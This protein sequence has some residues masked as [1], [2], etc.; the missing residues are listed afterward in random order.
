[1]R[2]ATY[3]FFG[4]AMT[5]PVL[6]LG[7][8][9]ASQ[10]PQ[11]PAKS[12][13][14]EEVVVTARLRTEKLK[15]V[16]VA[17]TALSGK[18]LKDKQVNTVKDIAAYVP[19]LTINSDSVS[20][21]FISIRGVGTTLIDTVQPGV[22]IFLNGVYEPDTSYLQTP[23]VDVERVEVLKGPQ[24][25]LFGNNT[26]GGAINVITRPPGEQVT[27]GVDGALAG[28]DG[29]KSISG[30]VSGPI[31]PGILQGRLS[32]SD[33]DQDG[34][35]ENTLTNTHANP[36]SQ[37]SL[38][39]TLRFE[40]LEWA[41]F[42]LNGDYDRV[43]G[44]NTPYFDSTGPYDYT[45]HGERNIDNIATFTYKRAN[46]T[47]VFDVAALAT[48]I[49]A[50]VAYDESNETA[51]ADGDYSPYDFLRSQGTVDTVSRSAELRADT[52]YS[53][54]LSSLVGIYGQK[55]TVADKVSVTVVPYDLTVPTVADSTNINEAAFG[56]LF[57]KLTPTIDLSAGLRYDVQRLT[58]TNAA[59]ANGYVAHEFEPRFTFAKHWT[60]EIMTYL[61]VARGVRGGGENG[62]GAPNP[63]Y[64]G[65][66]VWTYEAGTKFSAFGN[67][68]SVDTDVFYNDYSDFIGQNALAPSTTGAGFVAVNLN[69]GQAETYGW[70]AELHARPTQAWRIDAGITLLHARVTNDDEFL[71][72]TGYPLSSN[73]ILFVPDWNFNAG[74]SYTQPISD[75]DNLVFAVDVIGKGSRLGSSLNPAVAP[76]LRAYV[77]TNPSI[78][79][80]HKNIAV[81]LFAT[82]LFDTRYVESYL[83][84]SLLVRAGVPPPIGSDLSIQGDR[85]RVG[86]RASYRF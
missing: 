36:L 15:N 79:W 21:A 33:H 72:T 28:P 62:P 11:P 24:G 29:Y 23:L 18:T 31:I 19:G 9:P 60:P 85:R 56:N 7:Q 84:Q 69:S 25:T 39:G 82:N 2:A 44:G 4:A 59:N 6:A 27:A 3:L 42:T 40:P 53:D 78:T 49:T 83:D 68:L 22:G 16:P 26:L 14:V 43:H 10:S 37:K 17:V 81:S 51:V 20:R 80:Q 47:G 65:D 55:Y 34:F 71:R 67:R 35:Q 75:D 5:A 12:G 58:A 66:S 30:F 64:H 61:S 57:Y 70:E 1:M 41:V 63:L 54:R 32:A 77:L 38:D 13:A 50:T 74:T 52:Q 8:A 46:L 48:K 45:L 73:H 86:L 76:F